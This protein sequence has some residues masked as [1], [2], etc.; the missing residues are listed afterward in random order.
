MSNEYRIVLLHREQVADR[1][2]SIVADAREQIKRADDLLEQLEM[3]RFGFALLPRT[4]P[5]RQGP[6]NARTG[7]SGDA[8]ADL[9]NSLQERGPRPRCRDDDA[10]IPASYR[11]LLQQRGGRLAMGRR[12]TPGGSLRTEAKAKS[13]GERPRVAGIAVLV[14]T[15]VAVSAD[16]H[17]LA[18]LL[19]RGKGHIPGLTGLLI[20]VR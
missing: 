14:P 19:E 1:A 12:A 8:E 7:A 4:P 10:R 3:Q 6:F 5:G 13:R 20:L 16:R 18:V 2:D 17:Q 9:P 15:A 11:Q